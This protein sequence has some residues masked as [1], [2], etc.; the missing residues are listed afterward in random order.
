MNDTAERA[1][2]LP[3]ELAQEISIGDL[4]SPKRELAPSLRIML[5]ERLYEQVKRLAG[6]MS[7]DTI[8][9]PRHLIGKAEACFTVITQAI[10]WNI[11]P[12][13][14]ARCTYQTP[15]GSIGFEG[16]LVQA[17]LEQ[18]NRFTG[19]P[20]ATYVGDWSKLTGKFEKV[21]SQKGHEY[22]KPT[23]T[24]A[25][26]D[27]LGIILSWQVKGED[28]PRIWPGEN[29]PF[30]LTQCFPLNSPLWATD[31]RTQIRYLA[32]RRFAN[33]VAPG[34]LGGMPFDH[35]E[36]LDA[37]DRA[38]DV[39]PP[40]RPKRAD[41]KD[42]ADLV[43]DSGKTG[44]TPETPAETTQPEP[45]EVIDMVGN[46]TLYAT[47]EQALVAYGDALDEAEKQKGEAGLT[48]V[49]DNNQGF[50]RDL[51]ERGHDAA[52]KDL[53]RTY[54]ERR[55]AAAAREA[56][57][58]EAAE[59]KAAPAKAPP[60]PKANAA[61][62]AAQT[63]PAPS[64]APKDDLLAGTAPAAQTAEKRRATDPWWKMPKRVIEGDATAFLDALPARIEEC[65]S[66]AETDDIERHN[67]SMIRGLDANQRSNLAGLFAAR[68]EQFRV[69]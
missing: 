32:V 58:K 18:S 33:G 35:D 12:S 28:E 64:E 61:T 62:P 20:K 27:G 56:A 69:G 63:E 65:R 45:L 21:T 50:M 36:L 44:P 24:K 10:N 9:T 14:V 11:D 38:V 26:A 13:F 29:E 16:K 22:V 60:P 46:V 6:I 31:P 34:I 19:A 57:A 41:F 54:G 23:W 42:P 52:T 39:T 3:A 68:R 66:W 48:T 30:Y 43:D 2:A 53:S 49:W 37:S 17:I 51:D 47:V 4:L 25:D 5:D 59:K 67:A 7:K 40:P 15:G 55:Q 1:P 8:F